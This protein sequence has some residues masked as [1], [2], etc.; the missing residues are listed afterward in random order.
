MI[1]KSRKSKPKRKICFV[2]TSKIHYSR[3]KLI[4]DKLRHNPNIELQIVLGGSAILDQ[5]GNIEPL[6]LADGY[7]IDAKILM[8]VGGGSLTAMAKTAGLGLVEFSTVLE[9]LNPDIVVV[10]GDRFE[11]LP[12]ALAAAYMNKMVA[13][14][15]GGDIT[16]TIDESVRHAITKLAHI[17]FATSEQ[18]KNRIIRMGENPRYTFNVG[19]PE[20]EFVIKNNFKISNEFV[21]NLGV[22]D[23]ID[24]KKPY[25]IVMQHPVTTEMEQSL[26]QIKHTLEAVWEAKIPAIWFWPNI[27]AGTDSISK[28][29][30]VFRENVKPE[31]IRFIRYIPAEHFL[32]LLEGSACLV[33][34]SSAGLKE[35]TYLGVPVVNIGS[36]QNGR[37]RS[38][39]VV[40]VS[41]DKDKIKMAILSQVSKIKHKPDL[42]YYKKDTSKTIVDILASIKLYN[43]KQFVE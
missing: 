15:E 7:K 33:G 9:R 18:S 23:V 17:H 8:V 34:N 13:H 2:I 31:H 32:G 24:I 36:R 35:C 16:G 43:Q 10:R 6:L 12:L 40:D 20:I 14:I 26:D 11:V 38:K 19:A 1:T 37:Y 28:G 39:N 22:G 27:D 41:Y 42:Y 25:I 30:R 3:S 4:L 21:N 5:Y 29:I